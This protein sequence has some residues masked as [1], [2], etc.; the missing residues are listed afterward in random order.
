MRK[1]KLAFAKVKSVNGNVNELFFSVEGSLYSTI[2]GLAEYDRMDCAKKLYWINEGFFY[3]DVETPADNV[4]L[5][6][7]QTEEGQHKQW[8]KNLTDIISDYKNGTLVDYIPAPDGLSLSECQIC[9]VFDI[10]GKEIYLMDETNEH[11]SDL[12]ELFEV[13]NVTN[14]YFNRFIEAINLDEIKEFVNT[15][16]QEEVEEK[17]ATKW[18]KEHNDTSSMWEW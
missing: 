13:E 9:Y 8:N 15:H 2:N 14:E 10:G 11:G 5:D 18:M 4:S 7:F 1:T 17:Y 6:E 16:T 3:E 12:L